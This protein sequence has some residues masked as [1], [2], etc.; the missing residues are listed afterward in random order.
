MKVADT[1]METLEIQQKLT[2][3]QNHVAVSKSCQHFLMFHI[4][5]GDMIALPYVLS[6][7]ELW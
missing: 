6:L 4:I 5:N 2:T 1:N 3:L 7:V